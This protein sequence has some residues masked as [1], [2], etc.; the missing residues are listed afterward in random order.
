MRAVIQRVKS[1]SVTVA[2]NKVSEIGRG[3]LALVG[4]AEGD[5][6]KDAESLAA[7]LASLRL[8]DESIASQPGTADA[9]GDASTTPPRP[10][11]KNVQ[12]IEGQVLCVSQF[13]LLAKV[14]KGSKP[15][16]HNA[17]KGAAA[18]ELYE[19]VLEGLRKSLPGEGR[20]QDGV[21]G[22]MMDVALVNDGPVTICEGLTAASLTCLA[23]IADA[24]P[25]PPS[26]LDTA[27][28]K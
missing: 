28:K 1:A 4:V 9:E 5:T 7:K 6:E 16:F 25:I 2:G 18:K 26:V 15:D 17:A 10:W 20:V 24:E 19:K 3:M 8:W 13:T 12:E 23:E 27:D 21:F 22:A 14:Q 11:R